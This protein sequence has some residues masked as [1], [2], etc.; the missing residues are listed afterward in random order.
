MIN[1]T[2]LVF[3]LYDAMQNSGIVNE[4]T[5][6]T[7]NHPL[8]ILQGKFRPKILFQVQSVE[9]FLKIIIKLRFFLGLRNLIPDRNQANNGQNGGNNGQNAQ[10][11]GQ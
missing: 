1:Q 2:Q 6:N 11:N 9:I 10:N 3:G 5:E 4:V 8:L 7:P